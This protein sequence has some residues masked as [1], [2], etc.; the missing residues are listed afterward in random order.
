MHSISKPMVNTF[1]LTQRTD[2]DIWIR[3]RFVIYSRKLKHKGKV[4]GQFLYPYFAYA[5]IKSVQQY[6]TD[7]SW[8]DS[9]R[10]DLLWCKL[11]SQGSDTR[12]NGAFR[13][14]I[15]CL[16]H[17]PCLPNYW[18]YHY[19]VSGLWHEQIEIKQMRYMGE[20]TDIIKYEK[21]IIWLQNND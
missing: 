10:P 3:T 21:I 14:G 9:I 17:D 4:F 15:G 20:K 11:T 8:R 6:D 1:H 13:G 16:P 5:G 18:G 12:I 2:W 19:N 7:R